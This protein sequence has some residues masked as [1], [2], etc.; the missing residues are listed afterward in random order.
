MR[1]IRETRGISKIILVL[2]LLLSFI[3]GAT[4]SY[5]WT[6]GYY[7]PFE[8]QLP[9]K[10]NVTIED[11]T[12][13]AQDTSFFEVTIL[14]P[15]YSKSEANITQIVALTNDGILHEVGTPEPHYVLAIGSSHKFRGTWNWANYT[16]Q[17]LKVIA[18]IVD[19]SGPSVQTRIPSYVKLA[20][21][22]YFNSSIST[23]HF[24][25]SIQNAETSTT[26]VN[27][28]ELTINGDPIPTENITVASAS[29]SFP[30]PLSPNESILFTCAWNWTAYQGESVTVAVKTLQGYMA[31]HTDVA[32]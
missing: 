30:Y 7:A 21:Q 19:G 1:L 18:F 5:V 4:L 8:F 6:M 25:V 32:S 9:K 13:S 15:S 16:G 12:F 11:V 24:N 27:I 10:V 2:I 28:T 3:V 17:T 14:N 31:R 22:A 26:Y 29:T 23:Q 20:A